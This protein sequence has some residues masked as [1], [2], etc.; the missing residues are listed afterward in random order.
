MPATKEDAWGSVHDCSEAGQLA[1]ERCHAG[2][3]DV[4]V[5][6]VEPLQFRQSGEMDENRIAYMSERESQSL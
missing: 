3:R 2:V 5:V 4:R 1:F 6:E